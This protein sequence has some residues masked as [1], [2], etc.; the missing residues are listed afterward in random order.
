MVETMPHQVKNYLKL[1]KGNHNPDA[2]NDP[3]LFDGVNLFSKKHHLISTMAIRFMVIQLSILLS[4]LWVLLVSNRCPV[5]QRILMQ[6]GR[7]VSRIQVSGYREK[8]L[9]NTKQTL[10][11]TLCNVLRNRKILCQIFM[12][13][14]IG[15]NV[16][17]G[18]VTEQLT[19][20][21]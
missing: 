7:P 6:L 10:G 5:A 11:I 12:H 18:G 17:H 20:V 2:K 3:N 16:G 13:L 4:P 1:W 19:V 21:N 9:L 14:M 15:P 8:R